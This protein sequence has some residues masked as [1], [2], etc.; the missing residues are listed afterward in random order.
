[1]QPNVLEMT[2]TSDGTVSARILLRISGSARFPV[3]LWITSL[4]KKGTI[5]G[6]AFLWLTLKPTLHA[7]WRVTTKAYAHVRVGNVDVKVPGLIAAGT[8]SIRGIFTRLAR[9]R[10]LPE[11]EKIIARHTANIDARTYVASLWTKLHEPIVLNQQP[12]VVLSMKPLEVFAQPLS[13]DAGTLSLNLG[14][15]TYIQANIGDVSTDIPFPAGPRNDLPDIRFVD[16]LEPGYDVIA[17]IQ[18]TYADLEDMGR[19]R[20][21]KEYKSKSV[22]FENLTL[23][24]SGA[25]LA[26]GVG[27]KMPFLRA[28][29]HLYLLG[30]PEFDATTISLSVTEFDYSFATRSLLVE[31]AERAGEGII[32]QFVRTAVEK[33]LVFPVAALREKVSDI[34]SEGWIGP[35]VRLHGTVETLTPEGFYLTQTGVRIP[36]RLK[37][38]LSCKL[39]LL[40]VQTQPQ[41]D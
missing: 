30:T 39:I 28:N 33:R 8:T 9:R 2:S 34:V 26:A 6:T 7:D 16:S 19:P 25:Q 1:M 40:S 18:I 20:I 41:T 5:S 17:P 3:D 21:E 4:Q 24:G 38:Y 14:I 15:K 36:L 27:F 11:L 31:I 37:G 23:Y 29:G 32:S 10:F 35:H 12:P 13:G 22:A